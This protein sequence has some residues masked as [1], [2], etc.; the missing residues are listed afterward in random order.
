MRNEYISP[1]VDWQ[2]SFGF[3]GTEHLFPRIEVGIASFRE[4][5]ENPVELPKYKPQCSWSGYAVIALT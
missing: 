5:F 2:D 1:I 4:T 3:K